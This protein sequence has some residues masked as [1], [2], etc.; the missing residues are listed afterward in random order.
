MK[1]GVG[2]VTELIRGRIAPYVLNLHNLAY[3]KGH[4]PRCSPSPQV[5]Y[6][7][8]QL[9]SVFFDGG[10]K[11]ASE[12]PGAGTAGAAEEGN[13]SP[14]PLLGRCSWPPAGGELKCSHYPSFVHIMF[15]FSPSGQYYSKNK[16]LSRVSHS[17]PSTTTLY[18]LGSRTG[19]F[20]YL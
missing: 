16:P 7:F 3:F 2:G 1:V 20:F 18:A 14:S 8:D 11:Y 6:F 5:H 4:C 17:R 9:C 15:Q 10:E 12:E 13:V 19:P